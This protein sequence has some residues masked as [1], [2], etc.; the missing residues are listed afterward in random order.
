MQ[1]LLKVFSVKTKCTTFDK[2][3]FENNTRKKASLINLPFPSR[4]IYIAISL[5]SKNK[6]VCLTKT[7]NHAN[8]YRFCWGIAPGFANAKDY[9]KI[10]RIT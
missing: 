6:I 10:E 3:R 4:L 7:G 1:Y 8:P 9:A 2:M 5:A